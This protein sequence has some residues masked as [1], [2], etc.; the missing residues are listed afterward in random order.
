LRNIKVNLVI[1]T[2]DLPNLSRSDSNTAV[3]IGKAEVRRMTGANI[4][5]VCIYL[6]FDSW[7]A[8]ISY[9]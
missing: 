3:V 6:D 5:E 8:I 7:A 2:Q 9:R 4:W 1:G